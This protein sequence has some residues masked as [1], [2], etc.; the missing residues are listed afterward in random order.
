MPALKVHIQAPTFERVLTTCVKVFWAI[1]VAPIPSHLSL[2]PSIRLNSFSCFPHFPS[3]SVQL[4]RW[5]RLNDDSSLRALQKSHV[6]RHIHLLILFDQRCRRCH[7][8][9]IAPCPTL[10]SYS[11]NASPPPPSC[12]PRIPSPPSCS[13]RASPLL[14]SSRVSSP[15]PSCPSRVSPPPSSCP[16][17]VPSPSPSCSSCI[18]HLPLV[19]CFFSSVVMFVAYP[20]CA[21]AVLVVRARS[22][23]AAML[24]A[25]L[26]VRIRSV[27]VRSPSAAMLVVLIRSPC[28]R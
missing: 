7:V 6:H 17:R 5:P 20:S 25:A 26:V 28:F 2:S 8:L 24:V 9:L 16:P 18:P 3:R 23:S 21:A 14:R 27:H 11:L 19:A 13:P 12:S 22:S 4:S 15:P 1:Q 10:P